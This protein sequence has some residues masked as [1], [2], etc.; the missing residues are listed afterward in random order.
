MISVI[1]PTYNEKGNIP[2][3]A[4]RIRGALHGEEYEVIFVDDSTDDTPDILQEV[5]NRYPQFRY[6]HRASERGLA[7]AV[8]RGF[9]AAKG[10]VL[11]V[12][13][14][15]LQHPPELLAEMLVKIQQGVD[16]VLPSR[17]LQGGE[18]RG[19]ALHRKIISKSARLI[20]QAALR[21]VRKVT[22][23]MSGFF[24]LR[25]QVIEG[26]KWN[27]IG[28]KILLEILVKGNYKNA[29]EIPYAFQERHRDE[30]KMSLREQL[31]YI[32][33]VGRLVAA[34]PEDRRLLLFL[35]VG[36]SGVAVN[37]GAFTVFYELLRWSVVWSG[38]FS[39]LVA[40]TSNFILN[41][42]FTWPG[43]KQDLLL[44]RYLKYL[45]VSVF[46]IAINL[47]VLY[48]LHDRFL[49]PALLAN[50]IG[51]VLMTG[52]NFAIN[53]LWTWKQRAGVAA[54]SMNDYGGP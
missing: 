16:L 37:M 1:I 33:H 28:W 42:T 6:I 19:L 26:I 49:L 11:A 43:D 22:D 29:L 32:R 51:I 14:A 47:T 27:P 12:M 18:D 9:E 13:D 45:I 50:A 20:G 17:F 8:I 24:M 30:S 25:K 31:N 23:P 52:W 36:L 2:L 35:L 53:S 54:H 46:G 48:V 39:A 21:R 41:D 7:T 10:D 40:M 4:D 15:D 34:S 38:F 5:A 3:L 44:V